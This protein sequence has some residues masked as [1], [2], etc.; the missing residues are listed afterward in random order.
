[1]VEGAWPRRALRAGAHCD[2]ART[3]LIATLLLSAAACSA[4]GPYGGGEAGERGEAG[5][6]RGERMERFRSP[7][8]LRYWVYVADESSDAVSRVRF[9]KDSI[10][11][12]TTIAVGIMPADL[13]GP[14]GL[15]VSPDGRFWYLTTAH[16]TPWGRLWKYRTGT[17]AL[18]GS[19]QLGLFPATIGLTPDGSLAFVANFDL[20]G[21]PVPSTVSVVET[22]PVLTETARIKT[23]VKP[24]G[25]RVGPKGEHVYSVCAGS[26][27]LVAM[28][29]S[30][31]RVTRTLHLSA[32]GGTTCKPTWAQP[33]VDGRHVFVACNGASEVLDV[34]V[35]SWAVSRALP[36]GKAPYNLAVTRNGRYLLATDKGEQALSVIDL[37]NGTEAARIA[38]TRPLP[39]GVVAS[40]DSRYAFVTNE[41]VGATRS[42]VDVFD[43]D[44][45]KRVASV[46]VEHQAGGIAFWKMEP[47]RRPGARFGR[48]F[49][50]R[51]GER[52]EGRGEGGEGPGG[53]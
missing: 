11:V 51:P 39:H 46:E 4:A 5:P 26:D 44:G 47:L 48:R 3:L 9:D 19:V 18:V 31:P 50:R 10:S 43:L 29:V 23:C 34:D 53:S 40:P 8:G 30:E 33:S 14:H 1:M 16:G 15:A 17:D 45:K 36:V 52:G 2:G 24:H 28:T 12:D 32:T 41:A 21:E 37:E 25:V 7:E 49:G 22:G 6:E 13:D 35:D 20:H 27:E 42:T 38:T